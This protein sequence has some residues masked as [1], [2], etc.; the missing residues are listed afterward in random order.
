MV[1]G[2]CIGICAAGHSLPNTKNP[3]SIWI[4]DHNSIVSNRIVISSAVK[5]QIMISSGLTTTLKDNTLYGTVSA[6]LKVI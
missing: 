6:G 1:Q 2:N 4:S 5:T 3:V